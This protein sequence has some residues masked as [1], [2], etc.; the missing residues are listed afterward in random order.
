MRLCGN[1]VNPWIAT[2]LACR[3][4]HLS[5]AGILLHPHPSPKRTK[6]K[7]P[8]DQRSPDDRCWGLRRPVEPIDKLS[9][10][11]DKILN[12]YSIVLYLIYPEAICASL[13]FPR[14]KEN[15]SLDSLGWTSLRKGGPRSSIVGV[16]GD[17]TGTGNSNLRASWRKKSSFRTTSVQF[18]HI[19][20]LWCVTN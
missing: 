4:A 12:Q 3:G 17:R 5:N 6:N 2:N 14:R 13:I 16:V 18:S 20:I 10:E 11:T 7:R 1:R 9:I 15:V 19:W 8:I